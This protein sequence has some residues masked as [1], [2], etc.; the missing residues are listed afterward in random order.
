VSP[1][2]HGE[3]AVVDLGAALAASARDGW[4]GAEPLAAG[5]LAIGHRTIALPSPSLSAHNCLRGWLPRAIGLP[6]G[7]VFPRETTLT[8]LVLGGLG[9]VTIPGELQTSLG[10]SI[11]AATMSMGL[12]GL[13]TTAAEYDRPGYVSC[14]TLYGA[15][16]G[17]CLADAAAGA[18]GALARARTA[19]TDRAACDR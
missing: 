10:R 5:A 3:R 14:A 17:R 11:K 18:V 6:L 8:A 12:R 16:L 4:R 2:R 13:V 19:L 9:V 1:S 15:G 7:S